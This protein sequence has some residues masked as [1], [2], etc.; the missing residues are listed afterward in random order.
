MTLY[1]ASSVHSFTPAGGVCKGHSAADEPADPDYPYFSLECPV[2]EP[3]LA[4]DPFWAASPEERPLTAAEEREVARKKR[5]AEDRNVQMM[6]AMA[7]ELI[8]L[9]ADRDAKAA[10]EVKAEPKA[11][12]R[13]PSGASA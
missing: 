10:A 3:L 2:C 13:K 6:D 12:T 7:R 5:E 4:G 8:K 1:A 9:A 11:R